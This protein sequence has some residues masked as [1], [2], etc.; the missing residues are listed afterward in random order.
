MKKLLKGL[1]VLEIVIGVFCAIVAIAML[2]LGQFMGGAVQMPAEQQALLSMKV[3]A[4]LGLIS[5]VFN[6]FC[7]FF[8]FKG[9]KGDQR[10]LSLAVKMGW[11]GLAAALA[12]G[13]LVLFGDVSA[14]RVSTVIFSSIVPVLF[15]ISAKSVRGGKK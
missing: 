6:F 12:S 9:A 15:L 13:V 1:S 5:A 8:G 4:V 11:V 2:A 7:G 10:K 3:S 14:E